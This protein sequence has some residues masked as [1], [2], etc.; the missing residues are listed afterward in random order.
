MEQGL[1][2]CDKG[3]FEQAKALIDAAANQYRSVGMDRK[4]KETVHTLEQITRRT[5]G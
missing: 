1:T 5:N 4:F 2:S 3:D